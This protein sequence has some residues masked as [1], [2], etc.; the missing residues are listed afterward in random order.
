MDPNLVRATCLSA[1]ADRHW[2]ER[3]YYAVPG[4]RE[5]VTAGPLT[6]QPRSIRRHLGNFLVRVGRQVQGAAPLPEPEEALGAGR[7]RS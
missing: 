4:D 2:W 5:M 6:A 7:S 3:N 1:Q